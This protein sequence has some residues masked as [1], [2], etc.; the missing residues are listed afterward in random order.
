MRWVILILLTCFEEMGMETNEN[1]IFVGEF[2]EFVQIFTY[3][4]ATQHIEAICD[5]HV[6]QSV[7]QTPGHGWRG[8]PPSAPPPP[9]LAN[10]S[11]TGL[12]LRS[13]ILVSQLQHWR[14]ESGERRQLT[15]EVC[16]VDFPRDNWSGNSFCLA[17]QLYPTIYHHLLIPRT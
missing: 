3:S 1:V 5:S 7:P 8:Q 2:F 14:V 13:V 16:V 17:L 6:F 10:R 15:L 11:L 4:T 12:D 9:L